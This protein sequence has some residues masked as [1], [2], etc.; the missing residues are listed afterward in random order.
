MLLVRLPGKCAAVR[1]GVVGDA[2]EPATVDDPDP[3]PGQYAHG[4][5]VVPAGGDGICVDPGSPRAGMPAVISKTVLPTVSRLVSRAKWSPQIR[6]SAGKRK[7]S[8]ATGRGNPYPGAALGAAAASAGRAPVV[9]RR[10]IPA[11]DP[12]HA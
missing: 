11:A 3:G 12:A 2:V 1:G 4:V 9:P 5:R 6:Q 7:G 10:P 8:N